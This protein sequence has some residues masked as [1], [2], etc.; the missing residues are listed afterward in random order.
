MIEDTIS[1]ILREYD[2]VNPRYLD[3]PGIQRDLD[4]AFDWFTYRP[5]LSAQGERLV[6]RF[7]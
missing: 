6:I 7:I 5:V 4:K 2:G 1:Q 3:I